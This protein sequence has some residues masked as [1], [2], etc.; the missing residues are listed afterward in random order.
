MRG[1]VTGIAG[2]TLL[3][4]AL[5]AA[6]PVDLPTAPDGITAE[7][8][9]LLAPRPG[10]R[11]KT[12]LGPGLA[13][14]G[15][16]RGSQSYKWFWTEV[17][18]ALSAASAGRWLEVVAMMDRKRAAGVAIWGSRA[19]IQAIYAAYGSQ[20]E[21]AAKRSGVSLP[22]L[23]AVIAVESGGSSGAVSPKGAQGLMQLMPGTAARFGVTNAMDPT[24]NIRGGSTYL[25][26]LLNMFSGDAVLAVAAYNAGEGAVLKHG[27]VP[28]YSETR[29]YVAK[30]AGAYTL[31]QQLCLTRPVGPR[32]SCETAE[33]V[34]AD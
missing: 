28:P 24:Q 19:R 31:A 2:K 29:D 20:L 5:I 14:P 9:A 10:R 33:T 11:S 32:G 3:A 23:V 34:S 25:N 13:V 12:I 15:T 22:L 6:A 18:T 4:A 21:A 7:A 16:P 26:V 1:A 17:S 8:E 27:G 30:V